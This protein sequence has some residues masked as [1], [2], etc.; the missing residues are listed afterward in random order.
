[1][2]RLVRSLVRLLT[3]VA[4]ASAPAPVIG[5]EAKP[6]PYQVGF[7]KPGGDPYAGEARDGGTEQPAIRKPNPGASE[8][9]AG[10]V[11]GEVVVVA[12]VRSGSIPPGLG[13]PGASPVVV[14]ERAPRYRPRPWHLAVTP[15]TLAAD[16]PITAMSVDFQLIDDPPTGKPLFL[17]PLSG[18]LNKVGFYFGLDCGSFEVTADGGWERVRSPGFIFTR[19]DTRDPHYVR[20]AKGGYYLASDHEGDILS[21]RVPHKPAKGMHTFTLKVL[22]RA[23]DATGPHVWVGGY[24]RSHT[25]K[26][27]EYV[28]ALRFDGQELVLDRT[29]SPFVE[30][31]ENWDD[32]KDQTDKLPEVRVAFGTVRANGQRLNPARVMAYYDERVPQKARAFL[33]SDCPDSY[34]KGLDSELKRGR[35]VVVVVR[36]EDWPRDGLKRDHDASLNVGGQVVGWRRW[37]WLVGPDAKLEVEYPPDVK[38]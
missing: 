16:L 7:E 10:P 34:S 32:R 1:M 11:T 3:A 17:V 4:L 37:E 35:I 23:T 9:K 36:G 21:A 18:E 12:R 28:G 15:L 19:W 26:T 38:R 25:T 31:Y 27:V 2:Y 6:K 24:V 8:G 29:L 13:K 14:E 33:W 22:E 20:P 5:Q 30:V